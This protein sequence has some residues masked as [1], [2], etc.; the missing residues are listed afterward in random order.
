MNEAILLLQ[1][2]QEMLDTA[3]AKAQVNISLATVLLADT[4]RAI[5]DATTRMERVKRFIAIARARP[6]GGRWP[7][8]ATK[9]RDDVEAA[10]DFAA[11]LLLQAQEHLGQARH[12]LATNPG[13]SEA[14]IA[15]GARFQ[16]KAL[17]YI[18]RMARLLTEAGFGRD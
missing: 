4:D 14:I 6:L 11:E 16:A 8:I 2:A 15:D 12:K 10:A 17:T 5:A 1:T 3:R 7:M 18:E 13:L 9:Q